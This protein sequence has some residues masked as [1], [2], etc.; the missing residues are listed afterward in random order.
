MSNCRN[1]HLSIVT[2]P[3]IEPITLD[4]ALVQCHANQGVEDDWFYA[5]IK[6][7]R[8][9]AELFTRR[10]FIEQSLRLTFDCLPDFPILLPRPPL[11]EVTSFSLFD[12]EDT[13]TSISTSDLLIDTY[14]SPG[15]IAINAGYSFPTVSLRELNSIVIVYKAGYGTTADLVPDNLKQAM[16]LHLGYLY[17]ARSGEPE[18][19]NEQYEDLLYRQ[20]MWL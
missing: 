19:I 16:L 10:A 20:K 14:S 11:I 1:F 7:V 12:I 3:A 2:E 9:D 15:R 6:A 8:R 13:E 5:T 18:P 4:E 17:D